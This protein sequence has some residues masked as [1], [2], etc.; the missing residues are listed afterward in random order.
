MQLYGRYKNELC[1][2]LVQKLQNHIFMQ[3]YLNPIAFYT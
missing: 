2:I 1:M 3:F